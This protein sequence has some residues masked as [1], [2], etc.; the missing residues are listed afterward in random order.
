MKRYLKLIGLD[1]LIFPLWLIFKILVL[2]GHIAKNIL[3][4]LAVLTFVKWFALERGTDTYPYLSV[5]LLIVALLLDIITLCG[6]ENP[7]L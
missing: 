4:V 1:I 2:L 7:S 6:R 5:G 3:L